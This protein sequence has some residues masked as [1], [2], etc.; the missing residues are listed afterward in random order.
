MDILLVEDHAAVREGI[1]AALSGAGFGVVAAPTGEDGVRAALAAEVPPAVLITDMNL[2]GGI[3]GAELAGVLRRHWPGLAVIAM[4]G[5]P[6]L[7]RGL[8]ERPPCRLLVKPFRTF[9]LVQEVRTMMKQAHRA[10]P[11]SRRR[12]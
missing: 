2:G 7:L 11:P 10:V 4:S 12:T 5:D 9:L 6:R 1:V 8:P 3:D